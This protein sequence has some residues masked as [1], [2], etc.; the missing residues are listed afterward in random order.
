VRFTSAARDPEG[1]DLLMVWDFGDGVQAGGPSI[2]HT[3]R[4]PGTYTATLTVT[5]PAGATATASVQV[6]VSG[7]TALRS[8]QGDVAGE[9]EQSGAWV[10]APKSQRMRRGLRLRVACPER[11]AVRAELRHAGKRIGT[12][13]T[14]RIRDGRRYTLE[15]RLSGKV[16]RQLRAAMR[17]TGSVKVTAVL[18]VRTA[19][20][21]TT[22]RRVVRLRR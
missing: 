20:G 8:P 14:L 6:T 10:K 16:R 3:Y 22:I 1:K 13:R 21:R 15:L 19:E 2:S 4:T 12:S 7:P 9:S 5:D 17:R 18:R 11:C